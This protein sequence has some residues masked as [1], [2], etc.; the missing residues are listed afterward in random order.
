[1]NNKKFDNLNNGTGCKKDIHSNECS[2]C[3]SHID[4]RYNFSNCPICNNPLGFS[5]NTIKIKSINDLI[6]GEISAE[7]SRFNF[8]FEFDYKGLEDIKD[9]LVKQD[10]ELPML[11]LS[12][13][14]N[15]LNPNAL[16]VELTTV[17]ENPIELDIDVEPSLVQGAL[18]RIM[19]TLIKSPFNDEPFKSFKSSE[20]DIKTKENEI[21]NNEDS[22][23]SKGI[24]DFLEISNNM[25]L[26]S[27]EFLSENIKYSW[28]NID[29]SIK[30][31]IVISFQNHKEEYIEFINC[32]QL[33]NKECSLDT[34]KLI[35]TIINKRLRYMDAIKIDELT[36]LL[37]NLD[38][39]YN[40]YLSFDY[41]NDDYI[42]EMV[43]INDFSG[44]EC[45]W[46]IKSDTC[47]KIFENVENNRDYKVFNIP[48]SNSLMIEKLEDL[49]DFIKKITFSKISNNNS[50]I[51][52]NE[53]S[54]LED[55]SNNIDSAKE[56]EREFLLEKIKELSDE[57]ILNELQR[58]L[59]FK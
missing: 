34:V 11:I 21:N 44:K 5:L 36:L 32:T 8:G 38:I 28:D 25:F 22:N 35:A 52:Q 51:N 53:I 12:I 43:S 19:T 48:N 20:T 47:Y 10:M 33:T 46:I 4:K 29:L 1:M 27:K 49:V 54:L 7:N 37:D 23:N 16:K 3:G 6:F 57:D 18:D 42:F 15:H 26:L 50:D 41:C 55:K 30:K 58:R 56:K 31:D 24:V 40:K 9:F 59:S 45:L 39:K 17:F 14:F 2:V 13:P